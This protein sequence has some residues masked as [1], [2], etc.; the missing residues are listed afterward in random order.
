MGILETTL[1]YIK[2]SKQGD[3]CPKSQ[4]KKGSE[5]KEKTKNKTFYF[6]FGAQT[7]PEEDKLNQ[8]MSILLILYK[9]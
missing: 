6:Y 9:K 7:I 1:L 4:A 2:K 3:L 8:V 5:D